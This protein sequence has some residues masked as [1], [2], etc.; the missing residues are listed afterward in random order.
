MGEVKPGEAGGGGVVVTVVV[1]V[2][3]VEL[4][5]VVVGGTVVVVGVVRPAS[6]TFRWSTVVALP[7]T[8]RLSV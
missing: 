7:R 4:V 2:D 6:T 5:V 8:V 1:V 3:V